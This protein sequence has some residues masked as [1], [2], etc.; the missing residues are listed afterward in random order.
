MV[1]SVNF[2]M[3]KFFCEATDFFV[4]S[5]CFDQRWS[6]R[7]CCCK[8]TRFLQPLPIFS[9]KCEAK[10][11]LLM[12]INLFTFFNFFRSNVKQK[13]I[14]WN[15]TTILLTICK[16][17]DL[18]NSAN[19]SHDQKPYISTRGSNPSALKNITLSSLLKF[20]HNLQTVKKFTKICFQ[21]PIFSSSSVDFAKIFDNCLQK[22]GYSGKF[23]TISI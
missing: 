17:F 1:F 6:K 13:K 15:E 10:E 12:W 16:I 9:I 5:N 8:N 23:K 14:W 22:S 18:K 4:A 20:Y 11:D 7:D 3:K 21:L 19:S 2:D